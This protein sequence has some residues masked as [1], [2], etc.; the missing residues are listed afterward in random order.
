MSGEVHEWPV[1]PEIET[2]REVSASTD[3]EVQALLDRGAPI[4]SRS[5]S[6]PWVRRGA[7]I[8]AI[9]LLAAMVLLWLFL[10]WQTAL[11]SG[12]FVTLDGQMSQR[13]GESIS[14]TGMVPY[15]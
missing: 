10:P 8:G 13:L 14:F 6:N 2:A 11:Q 1:P 7:P 3:G 4:D 12:D 5:R 15:T 9:A